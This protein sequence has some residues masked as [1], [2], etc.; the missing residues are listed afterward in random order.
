VA[1]AAIVVAFVVTAAVAGGCASPPPAKPV[2][3]SRTTVVLLP[4]E[5]GHVGAVSVTTR[6]GSRKVDRAYTFA[7]VDG[8]DA[9]PSDIQVTSEEQVSAAFADLI[10]A[11]PPKPRSFTLYFVLD[12]TA[13]TAE[14]SA[15][16]PAIFEAVRQ[17]KPT[18]IS[19]LGHTD[20]IG[21]EARN[22]KLSAERA[23]A[24]ENILRKQDPDLGRIDV[25]FFGSQ[26]P[27]IPTPPNA[28]EPRNR[29]A[30]IQIL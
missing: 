17:R 12:S 18:E 26:E 10:R 29:R 14:S 4:D 5:D 30:E 16:L 28:T 21:P 9:R 7:T 20:A 1:R 3:T 22:L 23:R 27:L 8:A 15:V 6:N 24:V 19:I 13:L 2:D 11:Q 25:Q